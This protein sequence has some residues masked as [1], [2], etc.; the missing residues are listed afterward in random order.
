MIAPFFVDKRFVL[1]LRPILTLR[2]VW[3]LVDHLR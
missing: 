3:L 1:F 2:V